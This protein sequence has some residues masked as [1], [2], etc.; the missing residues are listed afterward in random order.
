MIVT[1]L[2]QPG[3]TLRPIVPFATSAQ[4]AATLATTTVARGLVPGGA[5][6]VAAASVAGGSVTLALVG[7]A[8]G[9][10][11]LVTVRAR[12]AAGAELESEV[13]VTVIDCTWALPDGGAPW[14]GIAGFVRRFGLDEVVRMTDSDGSG[15]IDRDLL[16]DA[17][18]DAQAIA[19]AHVADRYALPLASV[20][21]VL[22]MAVGDLARARLYPRGAPEGVAD[23]AKAAARLLER[24]QAGQVSLG[25][26]AAESPATAS[27]TPVLIAPG[28]RAYPDRLADY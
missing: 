22:E 10:R 3:E 25:L 13:E 11:Y 28:L 24:L 21:R 27:D 7:G 2:K 16:V 6:L 9:E 15:R 19:A 14:L 4:I 26:P 20:P 5:P 12:D 8:D 23:Q 18:T 1:L 17:L